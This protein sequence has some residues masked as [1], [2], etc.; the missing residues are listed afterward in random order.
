[1]LSLDSIK[2]R[3]DRQQNLSF[4]EFNYPI[5][6]AFDFLVFNVS[7]RERFSLFKEKLKDTVCNSLFK[8]L[9]EKFCVV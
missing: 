3:L 8:V 9:L 1:M 6:Q 7:F 4:L 2:L 5:F